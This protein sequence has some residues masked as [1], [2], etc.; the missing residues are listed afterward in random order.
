MTVFAF[1]L[2]QTE[3]IPSIKRLTSFS[4][5]HL[6]HSP[7][8]WTPRP[9]FLAF[10]MTEGSLRPK[11]KVINKKNSQ[12]SSTSFAHPSTSFAHPST[13][14][15]HPSTSFAHQVRALPTQVRALPT[16]VRALPTQV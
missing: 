9:L 13:S 4:L 16:Q 8:L 15:A 3:H 7:I 11:K 14:F 2:A 5:P 10:S 6:T 12:K 1:T